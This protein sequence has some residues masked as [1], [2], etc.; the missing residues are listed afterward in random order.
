M[1]EYAAYAERIERTVAE[2]NERHPHSID[3]FLQ[4]DY[5]RTLG[6]LR[7]YDVLLVNSIMDGMN[8]VSKEGPIVNERNGALVLSRGAGSFEELGSHAVGIDDPLD[9]HATAAALERALELSDEER[10]TA[11]AGLRHSVENSKP[12]EWIY[13][14]LE[15]LDAIRTT[16]AP[17]S[18]PP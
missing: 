18:P 13:A 1:P 2:V 4:D 10:A 12:R 14:Q 8:L 6:A 16:G 15:D 5:D 3:L 17:K 11:A 7:V 9:V